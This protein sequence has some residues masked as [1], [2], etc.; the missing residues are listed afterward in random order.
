ME[1]RE[2]IEMFRNFNLSDYE[3]KTYMALLF[4]G[5]SKVSQ[6]S[7]ESKVPQSK[8]YEVL[9]KLM[10]KQ[11]VEV[12]G[13]R[14]KEF[15]AVHP[16]VALKGLLEEKEKTI[17][18]MKERMGE[19]DT[20]LKQNNSDDQVMDGVWTS[21]ESG[22]KP[23]MD[24]LCDMYEKCS[25]Y[26]YVVTRDFTWS[27]RLGK[28]VKDCCKRGGEVKVIAIR[29]LDDVMFTR[30]K[31]FNEHGVKIKV[32]KTAVHPRIID[33]DGKEILLRLDNNHTKKDKF[34][35]TSL[36]SKDPALVK[37]I[38][39]YVKSMWKEG[40]AVNFDKKERLKKI[41]CTVDNYGEDGG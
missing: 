18:E 36:W 13:I 40:N 14:P 5:P 22:W 41:E 27:S 39:T 11:L 8:I 31:W 15:K 6:I 9:E 21:K 30:A 12:Y 20:F 1:K 24:R 38:D 32:F 29:E 7:R 16:N 10:T 37:I 34:S 3:S 25:K 23:F 19:L 17:S 28:S 4:L 33:V 2:I 26:I 35:F